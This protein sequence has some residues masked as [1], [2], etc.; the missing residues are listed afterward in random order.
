MKPF[1]L[2]LFVAF[3]LA[4]T[5][6]Q[7]AEI[8]VLRTTAGKFVRAAPDGS[9]KADQ[10]FPTDATRFEL[11][12]LANGRFTLKALNGRYVQA[13]DAAGHLARA[14]SPRAMPGER[15][16]FE[17]AGLTGNRGGLKVAGFRD[18]IVFDPTAPGDAPAAG[19]PRPAESLEIFCASDVSSAI[20]G[21]LVVAIRAVMQE[22]VGEKE[23]DQTRTKKI[24]KW[25]ELPAPTI[26]DPKRKKRHRVLA[27]EEQTRVKAK[28]DAPPDFVIAQMPYLRGYAQSGSGL[29]M[30]V[31][32]A[33]AAFRG[34]VHYK[35]P[36]VV[37]A[38]T[39]YQAAAKIFL[40]GELRFEKSGESFSF[41]PA[42]VRQL[43]IS[44][45]L[46]DIANDVA[47]LGR[48]AIERTINHELRQNDARL[49]EQANKAL[50]KALSAQQFQH[51]LLKY[52]LLP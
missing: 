32:S 35:M 38:G 47:N 46:R 40:V 26:K 5:A 29:I 52:L 48:E 30:F 41:Q 21:L 22:E 45:D 7:A 37:S 27:T 20:Q 25:I 6:N 23:Y 34:Q 10:A 9:L 14:D 17:L 1:W 4:V 16:T 50:A 11:D 42:E 33:N 19:Q 12:P 18:F 2:A 36:N 44:L 51:P 3:G 8:V 39:N 43:D 28:L 15:E 24:E 31:A 13:V 49:R